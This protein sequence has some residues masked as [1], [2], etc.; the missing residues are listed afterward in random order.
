[1][2]V[3]RPLQ[4]AFLGPLMELRND[5]RDI[6]LDGL[7]R[8]ERQHVIDVINDAN[9]VTLRFKRRQVTQIPAGIPEAAESIDD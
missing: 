9:A 5:L 3:P 4:D 1:M 7:P 8:L 6:L 2:A